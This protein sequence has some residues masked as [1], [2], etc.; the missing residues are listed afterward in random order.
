MNINAATGGILNNLAF[1]PNDIFE[2]EQYATVWGSYT[3]QNE[4]ARKLD[5]VV[6]LRKRDDTQSK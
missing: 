3:T 4:T 6:L 2:Y 1:H 5:I